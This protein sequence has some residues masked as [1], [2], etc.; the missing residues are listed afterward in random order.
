M[1]LYE[2]WH[3]RHQLF[4]ISSKYLT[5]GSRWFMFSIRN[6]FLLGSVV[7]RLMCHSHNPY[8]PSVTDLRW[9][10]AVMAVWPW[11]S[12]LTL[13]G[14]GFLT[15]LTRFGD[16]QNMWRLLPLKYLGYKQNTKNKCLI[17]TFSHWKIILVSAVL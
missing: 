10:L 5:R 8:A 2:N 16:E 17:G 15:I 14:L 1:K 6:Y 13:L 4:S 3:C 9:A 11:R 7:K 12:H